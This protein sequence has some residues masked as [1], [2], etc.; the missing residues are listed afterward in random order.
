MRYSKCLMVLLA[1]LLVTPLSAA[2]PEQESVHQANPEGDP[3]VKIKAGGGYKAHRILLAPFLIP[4]YAIIFAVSPLIYT[5]R[6]IERYHIYE[7]VEDA[8]T[9]EDRTFFIYPIFGFGGGSGFGGGVGVV[10]TNLFSKGYELRGSFQIFTNLD[11]DTGV[12]FRDR[13]AFYIGGVPVGYKI[14]AQFIRYHDES[15]FGFG[16]DTL[17]SD[18]TE[19]QLDRIRSGVQFDHQLPLNFHVKP[20]VVYHLANSGASSGLTPPSSDTFFSSAELDGFGRSLHHIDIGLSLAHDT[21]NAEV[22]PESGGLRQFIFR[23]MQGIGNSGFDYNEYR[24]E[25]RQY[26]RLWKERRV[27]GVRA[28]L[29]VQ[30]ETG[31]GSVPFY[32]TSTL[33]N[34]APLRSFSRGRFRDTGYYLFNAEYRYPVWDIIDAVVFVDAGR[35]FEDIEDLSFKGI[36]Y[37]FGGGIRFV[38]R[39]LPL[40]SLMVGT[41][42]EGTRIIFSLSHRL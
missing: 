16:N 19:F 6:T 12:S 42:K 34:N 13:K 17:E 20:H 30:D 7:R 8:L 41:G 10:H 31:S 11:I 4:K 9:N 26:F 24:V 33:D 27:L 40:A 21:R 22:N 36:K 38:S 2:E 3:E 1:L 29:V 5:G 37:S 28:F 32:R 35:V 23:R 14:L 15:F 18:E 39:K 25:A